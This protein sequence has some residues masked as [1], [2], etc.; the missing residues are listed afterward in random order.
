[1]G[2]HAR[3]ENDTAA[4]SATDEENG[5]AEATSSAPAGPSGV[6][7]PDA[8][9]AEIRQFAR[10]LVSMDYYEV[11]G[12]VRGVD[13]AEIRK[14]FFERSKRFHPDR[15]F[16]KQMGVYGELL[17]EIYKRIVVAHEV[18]R[19]QRLRKDY[20]RRLDVPRRPASEK[21]RPSLRSRK[22]LK[23][24]NAALHR[25]EQQ[26]ETGRKKARQHFQEAMI[27]KERGD[28][29]RSVELVRLAITFDPRE[30]SYHDAL[31]E[32]LP[33]VNVELALELR[34]KAQVLLARDDSAAALPFFEDAAKLEPTDAELANLVGVCALNVADLKKATEYT[35]RAISLEE[36]N[37]SFRKTRA[38]IY[39]AA[40]QPEEARKE[41]QRAWELDPL[42]EEVK[43]ELARR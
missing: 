31:A 1:M 41:F 12:I 18:L 37:P 43:A 10:S 15:Y 3:P 28:W 35:E 29:Q 39:R 24:P 9:Q 2:S 4:E 22:G 38:R 36:N 17:T 40:N 6:E 33:R 8:L 25:L 21:P 14:A 34:R 30:K 32:L 26:V 5:V 16:N 42:D 27:M 11:L 23:V 20:D 7:I 19:D 13:E